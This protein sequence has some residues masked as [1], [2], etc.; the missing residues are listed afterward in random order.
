MQFAMRRI[1]F[2]LLVGTLGGFSASSPAAESIAP[3]RIREIAAMLPA[4]PAG[5]GQPVANRAAWENFAARRAELSALIPRAVKLA[6]QPLPEQ[7]DSLFLEFSKNGNRTRWQNV[8]NA[9]RERVQIFTLAECLENKGRFLAPLEKTIAALCAERTWVLSAHDPSLKNFRG[10]TIEID[11]GSSALG[12]E[13]AT[14]NYLLGDRLSPATRKLIREN[15]ERRI[16]AP[17]RAAVN[18]ARPEFWWMRGHNNWNAVCLDAV[19]GAALA[20]IGPA[21][22]RAWFI[23][24]AEKN[25]GSYLAGGFTPDGYCVEGLGYWNYGFGNFALLAENIRHATGG[26]IDLLTDPLAAQPALFGLRS[27]ILG[28][29]YPTIADCHP[30]ERP[31]GIL[32][33]YLCRRLGLDSAR[34]R[35]AELSGGL[36]EKTAMGFLPAELPQVRSADHPEELPW[37]TWFPDGG[38]LICRPGTGSKVPFAAAL[39]GGNNGVSHGHNDVGSFSV[40][41]GNTMVI[42]DPGGEVYT[43]RTFSAHRYDSKV[44]NSFGHDVPVVA[45]QLQRTGSEAR[46]AL[47]AKEFTQAAD[48]ITL[49]LR[50]AYPVADLQKLERTFLFRRGESPSLQVRDEIKLAAPEEFETALVTW[51]AIR[52]VSENELEITDGKDA[53]RVTIDTQGRA[54][55]LKQ[56][57]IDENVSS[58]RQPVRLGIALAEKVLTATVTLR[59]SPVT[60]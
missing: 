59:I 36:Y 9:R 12:A 20:A 27:E 39:K 40:V 46:G 44:L 17:Y 30:G 45:G 52:Q 7:P 18:G 13:L 4:Q 2:C 43:A 16:F 29:V 25:I 1:L 56:E 19:T 60:K 34:W 41:V 51:G 37:R 47:V 6:A 38:V 32:M 54:F 55:Q 58:K 11:L 31:S 57:I 22:E 14:A 15:L 10:E 3:A 26:K 49:D 33:N 42:C 5:F 35:D 8:A 53:L 48:T 21:Q 24:V 23:A 28:G 50:S